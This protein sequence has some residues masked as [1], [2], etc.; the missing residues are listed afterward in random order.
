MSPVNK[1]DN[2]IAYQSYFLNRQS[3]THILF[4]FFKTAALNSFKNITKKC[5]EL[6]L[7]APAKAHWL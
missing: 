7:A 6:T 4:I 3:G 2:Q 1:I 5:D